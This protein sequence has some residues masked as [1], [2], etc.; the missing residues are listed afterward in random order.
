MEAEELA[1]EG[2]VKLFKHIDRFDMQRQ[3]D[4]LAMLKA[5]F[6]IILV[7]TCIDEYRRNKRQAITKYMP[8]NLE[9]PE[10]NQATPVDHL[11]YKELIQAT[12]LL[13]P[14]YRQVF[15]MYVIDGLNHEEI[16][17]ELGIS[18]GTSKS[19]LSKARE[20]MKKILANLNSIKNY[21]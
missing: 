3:S 1:Q 20:K 8:E 11:S 13:S 6:K 9:I 4:L 2:F 21:V 16:A 17:R 12:R 15:N 7:N 5:W 19:N 18:A 10:N 14:S